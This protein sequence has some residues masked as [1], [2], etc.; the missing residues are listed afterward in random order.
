M[1]IQIPKSLDLPNE[2]IDF[3]Q[4]I[5]VIGT[6][7]EQVRKKRKRSTFDMNNTEPNEPMRKKHKPTFNPIECLH[8]I[9]VKNK[10]LVQRN[11]TLKLQ[12][13]ALKESNQKYK[14]MLGQ[15][16]AIGQ[17]GETEN[18]NMTEQEVAKKPKL[19]TTR[20]KATPI[21]INKPSMIS[22]RS[23]RRSNRKKSKECAVYL[24]DSQHEKLTYSETQMSFD[25]FDAQYDDVHN[26]GGDKENDNDI[27]MMDDDESKEKSKSIS[28]NAEQT[29]QESLDAHKLRSSVSKSKSPSL[30]MALPSTIHSDQDNDQNK[31]NK[32][33]GHKRRLSEMD[34]IEE[35][36]AKKMRTGD[37]VFFPS[38]IGYS[39][40]IDNLLNML[41]RKIRL[42]MEKLPF[43][44]IDELAKSGCDE[45][46]QYL[47]QAKTD[48]QRKK[49][50]ISIEYEVNEIRNTLQTLCV[51]YKKDKEKE[52][53]LQ[54]KVMSVST[55]NSNTGVDCC[56]I[57][58]EIESKLSGA[59]QQF[60][61]HKHK[62]NLH[63]ITK[64]HQMIG[65]F[66]TQC[67]QFTSNQLKNEKKD[68]KNKNK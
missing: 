10:E 33:S 35:P 23:R 22:T 37:A 9:C 38:L 7:F 65:Q 44:T 43:K 27:E 26:D 28:L 15:L 63:Q 64:M 13:N 59:K 32:W 45:V 24:D 19:M 46:T 68:N 14:E 53:N 34:G 62:W 51:V 56:E 48:M 58:Q 16:M 25:I 21:A 1:A 8:D 67:I 54:L 66:N 47:L 52:M 17:H 42:L 36:K 40:D 57:I 55:S 29:M 20:S 18:E 41:P 12:C 11:T 31:N 39:A 50:M 49:E 30:P 60:E 4:A 61:E 6:H 2:P 5:D 3:E